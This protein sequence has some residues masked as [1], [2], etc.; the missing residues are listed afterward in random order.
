MLVVIFILSLLGALALRLMELIFMAY[1]PKRPNSH[2]IDTE[3]C[4]F[5]TSLMPSENWVVRDLTERD[6]GIDKIFERF[7]NGFATGELMAIQVKGTNKPLEDKP[8]IPFS[9][10]TKTLLYAEMF[11]IP[12]LLIRCSLADDGA[13]YFV[14]LQEY[15][16]VR[17]NFDNSSWRKQRSNT[18]LIPTSNRLGDTSAES[19]LIHISRFPKMKESWI[20]YYINTCDLAYRLPNYIE[21]DT[22]TLDF[23]IQYVLPVL[24]SLEKANNMLGLISNHFVATK[25]SQA[26]ELGKR[27]CDKEFESELTDFFF[28]FVCLCSD[29][30]KSIDVLSLR[31][32]VDHMRFLY[33]SEGMAEY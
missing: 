12:F 18:I 10:D 28:K 11:A 8:E 3:A 30:R 25:L 6:F 17:L 2:I 31:F 26:I 16:R 21:D 7:E 23:A 14:W 24:D 20:K 9:I 33:E 15:I 13:C 1:P 22:V 5:V 4:S 19:R 29:V 32:D 27:I